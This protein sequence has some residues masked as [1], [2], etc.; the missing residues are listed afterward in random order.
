MKI[1][2]FIYMWWIIGIIVIVVIVLLFVFGK[3]K[4]P[5]I[6]KPEEPTENKPME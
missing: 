6:Q 4:K 3:K 1:K 5:E 2:N